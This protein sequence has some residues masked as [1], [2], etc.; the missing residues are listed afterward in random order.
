MGLHKEQ[1]IASRASTGTDACDRGSHEIRF[2][3]LIVPNL[4]FVFIRNKIK[5]I[6]VAGLHG[7]FIAVVAA[8]RNK[9]CNNE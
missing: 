3:T 4:V 2:S 9:T 1:L 6:I 8:I 5:I 7:D